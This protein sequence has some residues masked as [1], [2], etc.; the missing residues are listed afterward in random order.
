M[1][2]VMDLTQTLNAIQYEHW[3][4]LSERERWIVALRVRGVTLAVVGAA[5]GISRERVRQLER[6]AWRRLL[7]MSERDPSGALARAFQATVAS[8]IR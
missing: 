8:E 2:I 4:L 5:W 6:G 1:N 7:R 3:L